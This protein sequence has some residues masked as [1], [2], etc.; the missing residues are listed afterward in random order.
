MDSKKNIKGL[1]INSLMILNILLS[2]WVILGI[3]YFIVDIFMLTTILFI[4]CVIIG[5]RNIKII[6]VKLYS[7]NVI[8]FFI[9]ALKFSY[10]IVIA[11]LFSD[12]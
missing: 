12:I 3:D 6:N 7:L 2:F 9:F 5:V 8:I 1:L 4:V 11:I 10:K